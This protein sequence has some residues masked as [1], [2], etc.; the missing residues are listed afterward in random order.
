LFLSDSDLIDMLFA[1]EASK[2]SEE[3]SGCGSGS[4]NEGS[5]S[6]DRSFGAMDRD[7]VRATLT[8]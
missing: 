5:G 3:D 2:D 8:V 7:A 6:E 1:L 4:G